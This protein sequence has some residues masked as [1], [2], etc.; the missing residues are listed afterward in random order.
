MSAL[1]ALFEQHAAKPQAF[2]DAQER[3]VLH[4]AVLARDAALVEDILKETKTAAQAGACFFKDGNGDTPLDI[5]AR[6]QD[7]ACIRLL[8]PYASGLRGDD[9]EY[10]TALHHVAASGCTAAACVLIAEGDDIDAKTTQSDH[11]PLFIAVKAPDRAMVSLLLAAGART[12]IPSAQEIY[13]LHVAAANDDARMVR[14]LV[15]EGSADTGARFDPKTDNATPAHV[16]ASTASA[17]AL[18]QL[19]HLGADLTL[20]NAQGRDVFHIAVAG[21]NKAAVDFFLDEYLPSLCGDDMAG[22]KKDRAAAMLYDAIFYGHAGIAARL[23]EKTEIDA[24]AQLPGGETPL[25]LA[26]TAPMEWAERMKIVTALLNAG[27]SAD[28]RNGKNHTPLYTCVLHSAADIA[29]L[30][31][32]RQADP[33]AVCDNMTAGEMAA[34]LLDADMLELLRGYG[35]AVPRA[36][37]RQLRPG[38]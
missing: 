35:A 26:I 20:E 5:A 8:A 24:D 33:A 32:M 1:R 7:P 25:T 6:L 22:V 15:E 31:L 29:D 12:D 34:R 11:T 38:Q 3:G 14:L 23:L 27:A 10:Y 37:A 2:R 28:A 9:I 21:G 4:L 18:R 16:A 30:L 19:W 36:T 17:S 13:P